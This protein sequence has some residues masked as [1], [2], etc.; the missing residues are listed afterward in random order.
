MER[1]D[2]PR[3]RTP[4]AGRLLVTVSA[5]ASIG[6]LGGC[7]GEPD[8]A[9]DEQNTGVASVAGGKKEASRQSQDVRPLFRPDTSAEEIERVNRVYND[10]L[11]QHGVKMIKYGKKVEPANKNDIAKGQK[12][13]W[14]KQPEYLTERSARKDPDFR[15]KMDRWVKCLRAHDIV[16]IANDDGTLTLP[17]SLPPDPQA[18]WLDRCELDV[19]APR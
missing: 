10:C 19:F 11:E 18:Q 3:P 16:A 17:N 4:S 1:T 12:H 15:E 6:V 7:T 9:K 13:C 5:L 14:Q 2:I 8:S